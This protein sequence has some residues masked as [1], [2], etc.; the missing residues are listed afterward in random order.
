MFFSVGLAMSTSFAF[1]EGVAE[2]SEYTLSDGAPIDLFFPGA[3]NK[4]GINEYEVVG[5]E[6]T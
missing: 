2:I 3:V 1:L 5:V 4:F 6:S